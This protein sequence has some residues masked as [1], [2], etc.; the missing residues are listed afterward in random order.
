M[1]TITL[2]FILNNQ[3]L[4]R[5]GVDQDLM[6]NDLLRED[7]GMTGTKFGCGI[8]VCRV[9]T[10]AVQRVPGAHLEPVRSCT[11]P[12]SSVQGKIVTT[13]EG[14][15]KDG[16]LHP[17]QQAFLKHFSFQC[18]YSAPGFLMASYCLID[19]LSHSPVS[20]DM[21]DN[22]I[23]E[24]VGQHVCR[25]TGYIRYHRAIKEVILQTRGLVT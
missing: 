18:G 19:K 25:C 9:C 14:L 10:V 11:T 12:V 21:V 4:V 17:L 22:V 20:R 16:V 3:R 15:E 8:A 23:N 5:E 6:L 1:T 7:L 13:V 2:E 24:A